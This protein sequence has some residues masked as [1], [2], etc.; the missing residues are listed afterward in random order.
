MKILII[1]GPNLNFVGKRE[2][3]IYGSE[4]FEDSLAEW[5]ELF[6]QIEIHYFQS[7]HEG[8]IIDRIQQLFSEDFQGLIINGGAFSHYSYAILDA[9][10]ILKI[11]IIEVHLSN[12]F[13]RE[14]FRHHSVLSAACEGMISG[15][16]MKSYVLALEYFSLK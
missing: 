9:L 3:E 8:A 11:P 14:A 12:I 2:P 10:R 13:K 4:N 6:P 5:K 16:G 7:N 1:N 15:F